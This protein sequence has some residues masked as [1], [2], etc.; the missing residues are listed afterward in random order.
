MFSFA[1]LV[2]VFCYAQSLLR[3]L[4]LLFIITSAVKINIDKF[5]GRSLGSAYVGFDREEFAHL[6]VSEMNGK[7]C[8]FISDFVF[9]S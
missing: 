8:I 2:K 5:S 4:Y 9:L 6:A 3:A 1:F 7:V